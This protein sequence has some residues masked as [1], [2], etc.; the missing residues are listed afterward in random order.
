MGLPG[1]KRLALAQATPVNTSHLLLNNIPIR[2][3]LGLRTPPRTRRP[4]VCTY[5]PY[6][7]Y[8]RLARGRVSGSLG[9]PRRPP[10]ALHQDRWPPVFAGMTGVLLLSCHSRE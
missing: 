2:C 1:E 3:A 9:A 7:I 5:R 8:R 6:A 10:W 4:G